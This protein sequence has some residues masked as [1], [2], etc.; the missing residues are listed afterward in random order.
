[1]NVPLGVVLA[2]VTALSWGAREILLRKAFEVTKIISGLYATMMATF[3]LS[4]AAALVYESALWS[5]LT[6]TI[7]L[8]W[9][10]IGALHFPFA[11]SLYYEGIDSIGGSR[12]SV[13]S[14][15]S[16][17]LTPILGMALLSEPSTVNIIAGVLTAGAGIFTVSTADLNVTGWKWQKGIWY[18][19]MAGLL[20][21]ITNFLTRYG[22]V[23]IPI[24]MTAL[25][26]ASGVPTILLLLIHFP[27]NKRSVLL[28]LKRSP[29]LVSGS[30]L[31]G[32]GQVTLFAALAFAPTV[33][34]VP[35]YNLKSLV[36]VLLACLFIS[37]SERVNRRVILGAVLAI[38]G[39]ALINI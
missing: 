28:D 10:A 17:I 39:I 11:M 6:L 4:L 32:L 20:W 15:S 29:R 27:K 3:I 18:G 8:L 19:L 2:L 23:G 34:V 35:T 33:Y 30:F 7:V 22:L 24:P 31:S 16:A 37:K 26:L 1:M 9:S 13:V 5:Q 12:T 14:N 38:G 21:S 25:A 36:T